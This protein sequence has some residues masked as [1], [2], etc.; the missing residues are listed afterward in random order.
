MYKF[1]KSFLEVQQ[2][3]PLV[4]FKYIDTFFIWTQSVEELNI[5]LKSL[6]EFD[7]SIKFTYESNKESITFLDIKI[8]LRNG[9]VFTGVCVKRTDRHQ[10]LHYLPVTHTV[11]KS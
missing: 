11:L 1:E 3:Q 6:N 4:R 10:Y 8:S 5:F 9:K 2:L 7:T